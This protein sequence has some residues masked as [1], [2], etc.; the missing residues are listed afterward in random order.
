MAC[1]V[2]SC[3]PFC[4]NRPYFYNLVCVTVVYMVSFVQYLLCGIPQA[5]YIIYGNKYKITTSW[6]L[7][8]PLPVSPNGTEN[9]RSR[10]CTR[11]YQ[12]QSKSWSRYWG[13][14]FL[15][16]A[17]PPKAI[18][19]FFFFSFSLKIKSGGL[20]A[21]LADP[22]FHCAS[23]P[24]PCPT[25]QGFDRTRLILGITVRSKLTASRGCK[26]CLSPSPHGLMLSRQFA[27]TEALIFCF[28]LF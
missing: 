9:L 5:H 21:I 7:S 16:F 8:I 26:A 19:F 15:C 28:V 6:N 3:S 25:L 18:F 10:L 14:G 2:L 23:S 22:S 24:L 27:P 13:K 11:P 1:P 17:F 4:F 20:L 12:Q